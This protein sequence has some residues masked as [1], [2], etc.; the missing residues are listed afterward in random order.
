MAGGPD[1]IEICMTSAEIPTPPPSAGHR[2]ANDRTRRR[3]GAPG[4]EDLASYALLIDSLFSSPTSILLSNAVAT[5][6]AF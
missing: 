5:L 1:R 3:E 6:V 2:L 4:E